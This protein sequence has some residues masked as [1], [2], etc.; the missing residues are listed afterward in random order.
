[1][2]DGTVDYSDV[3]MAKKMEHRLDMKRVD[4]KV[5]L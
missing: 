5:V 2:V 4:S 1:M 3:L